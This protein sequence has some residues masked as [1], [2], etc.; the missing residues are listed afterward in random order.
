MFRVIFIFLGFISIGLLQAQNAKKIDAYLSVKA[1]LEQELDYV[2][3]LQHQPDVRPAAGIRGKNNKAAFVYQTLKKNADDS[4]QTL[5][6]WLQ[7]NKIYYEPFFVVNAIRIKSKPSIMWLLAEMAE[8]KKIIPNFNLSLERVEEEKTVISREI[9]PEWGI[10]MIQADSVW[11]LGYNG[12]DVIIGGQDTGYDWSVSPLK[13]KY[14]G[15]INDSIANHN[16]NW[17]DAIHE[18][19]PLAGDSLNPCGYSVKEPCDD[20]NHGTHTMGTMVGQDSANLIGVAPGAQWMA[21]R[22][23]ERGNGQLSTY[24]EWFEWFLAPTDL[25]GLNADVYKAPHVINNS[26]YCSTEEG[27]NPDNWSIMETVVENLKASGV[28]VVVSAGNSGPSC[29][30]INAPPALFEQSFTVGATMVNDTIANF[31]SRGLVNIDGS[32]RMK[33]DVAAPGRGVRSVIR[34]GS[35]AAYNGTSM[36]GPHVAGLV[37]LII[38]AN[39]QLAGEVTLIETIIK[40]TAVPKTTN[41]DCS[42]QSGQMVPNPVYGFG[43]INALQAVEMALNTVPSSYEEVENYSDWHLFPNPS[44]DYINIIHLA[45][46]EKPFHATLWNKAG[47]RVLQKYCAGGPCSIDIGNLPSDVYFI[48]LQNDEVQT[49]KRFIRAK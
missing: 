1:G 44:S 45:K 19:S 12:Q 27:C 42:G 40:T 5:T 8:V 23:M 6:T 32:M 4:Q 11:R 3:I 30:S 14:R 38:S 16:Y 28:V 47:T 22:N 7:A 26:W 24:L 36:A 20:S 15:F 29:E 41:Q 34:G 33:P 37:A 9:K 48:E 18:K 21:C 2:V 31:S 46:P 10:T 49:V 25:N 39:P 17:H 35:F 13:Q 43:R